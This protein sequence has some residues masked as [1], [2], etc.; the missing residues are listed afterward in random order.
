[1][2]RPKS[3]VLIVE[4]DDELRTV[5]AEVLTTAGYYAAVLD[6]GRGALDSIRVQRPDLVVLD[7]VM[8]GV[9]GVQ[10]MA[11]VRALGYQFPIL[12]ITGLASMAARVDGVQ[13]VLAKPFDLDVF[14]GTVRR[15]LGPETG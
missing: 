10:V 5:L 6:D 4:D 7:V 13:A 14:L 12:L 15:L 2:T 1:M 3:R 9:D 8:A 11:A